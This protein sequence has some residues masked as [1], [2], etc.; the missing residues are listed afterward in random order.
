MLAR[1]ILGQFKAKLVGIHLA[2]L[3]STNQ[4]LL[5][6]QNARLVLKG[7][8]CLWGR[9]HPQGLLSLLGCKPNFLMGP[10]LST[11]VTTNQCLLNAAR[12]RRTPHKP[13]MPL[14]FSAWTIPSPGTRFPLR[15]SG[16]FGEQLS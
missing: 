14:S 1:G 6:S 12:L 15:I 2:N 4:T 8:V 9:P 11:R 16:T 13:Y 5:Q 10:E 3:S 7:H